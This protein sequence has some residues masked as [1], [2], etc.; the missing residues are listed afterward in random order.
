MFLSNKHRYTLLRLSR[1]LLAPF[2]TLISLLLRKNQNIVITAS[3]NNEFSD[4]AKALFEILI[5]HDDFKER[6]YFVLND[7]RLR[8]QLNRQ[9]PGRF[10]SN[11]TFK[12]AIFV[13]RARYWFCSAMELP[14]GTFF[15]RHLRQ[16]VHLGHGMLYKKVGF[17]EAQ[18]SW[19]KKLY[20]RLMTSSFTYTIATT[21]FCQ[22]D[23]AACFG[24]PTQRVL[25]TPQPKTA[26]VAQ[27]Q[28]V[29]SAI[30]NNPSNINILY[31]PTWRPYAATELLAFDDKDLPAFARFLEDSQIHLWLRLHPR[32]EHDIDSSLLDCKN[33]HLFSGK[34]YGEVN[35][36]LA[37]FSAL[38]TDYSSIFYDFITLERPVLFLDYDLQQYQS[39]VGL[40][41]DYQQVKCSDSITTQKQLIEHLLAVKQGSY[42]L[43]RVRQVNQRVNY[44]V[45]NNE[46]S[47]LIT[48]TLFPKG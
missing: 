2:F 10:I 14:L 8:Q 11:Q 35:S 1:I 40:I 22:K 5:Q 34:N 25:L 24:M 23:I 37:Y 17:C 19:Y 20:Y 6:V 9:Y 31:A 3:Y 18:I 47:Q 43:E 21:A 48:K 29:E 42:D 12:E 44:P 7:V 4:N 46:I 45:Q 30:L 38:I 41:D 15:Q 28:A 16:T 36:Y 33:I 32:L 26:Q 13:L 39:I 27:P